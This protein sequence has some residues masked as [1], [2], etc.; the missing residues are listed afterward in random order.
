MT[1]RQDILS[2]SSRLDPELTV[3]IVFPA[4]GLYE[5]LSSTFAEMGHAFIA[6]DEKAIIID[7]SVVEEEWFTNDH[8]LVIEA[9][10]VGHYRA[11]HQGHGD[12][13]QER[14][15]DTLGIQ[16]LEDAGYKSA[17]QLHRE[18]FKMR[19]DEELSVKE[20]QKSERD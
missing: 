16:A 10:E 5:E 17:A 1:K 3:T 12:S 4:S 13:A 2:Y 18:E 6:L 8:L 9:H 15:A 20:L 19:Y 11:G 7:G 14:E